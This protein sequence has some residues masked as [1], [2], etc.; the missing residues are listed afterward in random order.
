MSFPVGV[1]VSNLWTLQTNCIKLGRKARTLA[2][3][4]H[5]KCGLPEKDD[6]ASFLE[7]L[8]VLLPAD[9]S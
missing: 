2:I 5:S 6:L 8:E 3:F 9:K 7:R 1:E 4:L